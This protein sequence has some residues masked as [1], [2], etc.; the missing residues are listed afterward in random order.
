[1]NIRKQSHMHGEVIKKIIPGLFNKD[2]ESQVPPLSLK[3]LSDSYLSD[4]KI[5]SCTMMSKWFVLV[6]TPQ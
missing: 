1:M 4:C 2:G 6:E 5:P 3:V